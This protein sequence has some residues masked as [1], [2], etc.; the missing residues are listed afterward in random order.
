MSRRMPLIVGQEATYSILRQ[1]SLPSWKVGTNKHRIR[2]FLG[3]D[4]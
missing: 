3:E 4:N 2:I 1:D